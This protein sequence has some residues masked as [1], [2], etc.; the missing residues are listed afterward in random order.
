MELQIAAA[1]IGKYATGESGDTLEMTERPHGG[2]SLVLADGQRSGRSAK[3]I[4]NLVVRKTIALLAEG[5]R[6]GVAARAVAAELAGLLRQHR[7]GRSRCLHCRSLD[8]AGRS[9]A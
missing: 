4:S 1:K 8:R 9:R 3:I 7:P 5:A 2:V 6:D